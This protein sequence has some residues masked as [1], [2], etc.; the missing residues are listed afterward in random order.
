MRKFLA[1]LLASGKLQETME[2]AQGHFARGIEK[3]LEQL[4]R[5]RA[6]AKDARP[7]MA[8]ALAGAL[9]AVLNRWLQQSAPPAA[10]Q[11]DRE[12]H[13]LVW[14]GVSAAIPATKIIRR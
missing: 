1:S 4:P 12:Y 6:I 7:L 8:T 2:L 11:V 3:R 13:R 5:G 14:S 9:I 10:E